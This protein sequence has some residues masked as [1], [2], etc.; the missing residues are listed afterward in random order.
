MN[1]ERLRSKIC[2]VIWFL[3][4]CLCE[5]IFFL[6]VNSLLSQAVTVGILLT[7]LYCSVLVGIFP[8]LITK[9][10]STSVSLDLL[11]EEC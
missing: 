4:D 9:Q 2:W 1:P 7:S 11:F 8:S 6:F 5:N 10:A 3:L